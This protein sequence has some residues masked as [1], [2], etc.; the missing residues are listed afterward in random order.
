LADRVLISKIE[1][2][3]YFADIRK[4]GRQEGM[5][6]RMGRMSRIKYPAHPMI[7]LFSFVAQRF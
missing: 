6:N 1:P 5:L 3:K 7:L 4:P 2:K